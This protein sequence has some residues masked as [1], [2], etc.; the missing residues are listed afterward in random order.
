MFTHIHS[1]LRHYKIHDTTYMYMLFNSSTL[2]SFF[3]AAFITPSAASQLQSTTCNKAYSWR[4]STRV[5]R[6][7][8]RYVT[9]SVLRC[10]TRAIWRARRS[11]CTARPSCSR[12]FDGKL[13]SITNTS[14]RRSA[15]HTW[16]RCF[17]ASQHS[18]ASRRV[19][20]K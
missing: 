16:P 13:N 1:F 17:Q 15:R 12:V 19:I 11:S 6:T 9:D 8:Q 5:L 4:K 14:Y 3:Q 18:M 7:R 2:S 20:L 10:G